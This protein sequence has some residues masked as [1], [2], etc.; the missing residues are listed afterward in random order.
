[1]ILVAEK[2]VL[3]ILPPFIFPALVTLVDIAGNK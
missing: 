3:S 1:M 2:E